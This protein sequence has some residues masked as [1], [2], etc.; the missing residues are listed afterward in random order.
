MNSN[1][2]ASFHIKHSKGVLFNWLTTKLLNNLDLHTVTYYCSVE[3]TEVFTTPGQH[4]KPV[5][6][7]LFVV[8]NLDFLAGNALLFLL[9]NTKFWNCHLLHVAKMSFPL[10]R[11]CKWAP[12]ICS[13]CAL[14]VCSPT[15]LY[16]TMII[17]NLENLLYPVDLYSYNSP[18]LS[19]LLPCFLNVKSSA[20]TAN[21]TH[22]HGK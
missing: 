16:I 11:L 7:L 21:E 9:I 17:M 14:H 20:P 22:V 18:R 8:P 4:R 13:V 6:Q 15:V 10:E 1:Q 2:Q 19:F 3:V 5:F 12:L